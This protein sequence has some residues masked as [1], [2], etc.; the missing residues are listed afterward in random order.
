MS[1]GK[2][3]RLPVG[4]DKFE[5]IREEGFYYIDK[6]G[7]IRDLLHKWGEVNL[8]TRPRRFGKSLNMSM[9][10]YFLEF[11]CKKE[12]FDGLEIAK[13]AELCEKHMGQYPVISISL[14]DVNGSDYRMARSLLCS[15]I[16]SEAMRFQFLLEDERLSEKE[17][18]LYEQLTHVGAPGEASFVMDDSVLTGSLRT[19]SELLEKYYGR[20]VILLID[21]YDV[22]LAKANEQNYYDE[23]VLL[24]RSL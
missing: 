5:K 20:K 23:M 14:K 17:K 6:T 1:A 11:G 2:K 8:F 12:F 24:I 18:W 7:F 9:L 19:L 4:I 10:Q 15:V 22:P 21:E 3:K 16:G 13:D